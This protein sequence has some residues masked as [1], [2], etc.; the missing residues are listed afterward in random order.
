MRTRLVAVALCAAAASS[1]R[2]GVTITIENQDKTRTV[3]VLEGNKTRSEDPREGGVITI[4]D[5]DARKMVHVSVAERTYTEMTEAQMKAM[6]A[7]MEASLAQMPPEQRAQMESMGMGGKAGPR[8]ARPKPK[9]EPMGKKETV[10]GYK[11]E[12][13]R[14]RTEGKVASE[15]CYMPW[16]SGAL[17]REDLQPMKRMAEFMEA[18]MPSGATLREELDAAPGY[19]AIHVDLQ[20]EK[21]EAQRLVS[22]K[23]G[24]V[25][26][27]KFRPPAG[28]KKTEGPM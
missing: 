26:A 23:R 10:A 8:A 20:R 7:Q 22:I 25:A 28:Y 19:P 15:G 14:E 5:G 27:D 6:R 9:Y 21:G 2:A 4:F 11:C 13:Y 24:S 12:W 1:A 17:T 16:G 18:F 3:L